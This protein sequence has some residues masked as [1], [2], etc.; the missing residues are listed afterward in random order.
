MC[1]AP[2]KV[3]QSNG[4]ANYSSLFSNS[5]IVQ[6]I[7]YSLYSSQNTGKKTPVNDYVMQSRIWKLSCINSKQKSTKHKKLTHA[8]I[9]WFTNFASPMFSYVIF[10]K[11]QCCDCTIHQ[12]YTEIYCD[13]NF[14]CNLV[15]P[16]EELGQE[17]FLLRQP[18]LSDTYIANGVSSPMWNT[19][20]QSANLLSE[21]VRH[22]SLGSPLMGYWGSLEAK[23]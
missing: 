17:M 15:Q 14:K 21:R 9:F 16:R 7:L 10:L 22:R 5:E 12:H 6:K 11:C 19:Q 1:S 3:L 8:F 4:P 2:W 23:R 13:F 20:Q 18:T